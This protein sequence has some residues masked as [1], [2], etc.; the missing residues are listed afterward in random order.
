MT[1]SLENKK[2]K[3]MKFSKIITWTSV[4]FFY[5]WNLLKSLYLINLLIFLKKLK[6]I[7]CVLSE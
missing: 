4:L 3:Q 2:K 1:K 7:E 6:K 5:I